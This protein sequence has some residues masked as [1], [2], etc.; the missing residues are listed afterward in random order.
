MKK[1]ILFFTL[2]GFSV[3]IILVI[4]TCKKEYSYE[5]GPL[6]T[7]T[8]V[9]DPDE[10]TNVII[11]GNYATSIPLDST[12]YV[13]VTAHVTTAGNYT[14]STNTV[15]GITFSAAGN[16]SDTGFYD[17]ILKAS[18]TPGPEG[19]YQL[20]IVGNS[21]CFFSIEVDAK[22]M[23]DYVLSGNLGD[24]ESPNIQG[25]YIASV[26]LG[27]SNTVAVNVEVFVPGD[28][29]ISTDTAAGISF[30]ASGTFT[31]TGKQQVT[32]QGSG[33]PDAPGLIYFNVKGGSSQ[34]AFKLSIRNASPVATYVLQ[35]G[36]GNPNPCTPQTVNGSY[37]ALQP[38]S[39]GNTVEISAYVTV[40][41]NFTVSTDST[42][43]MIFKYSGEFTVVGEQTVTLEGSGTPTIPGTYSFIPQIIGPAPLG[44][45]SCGFSIPV[46]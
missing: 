4:S 26:L 21:T 13:Q 32:L 39:S 24:C 8:L 2:L 9:G 28:Y 20:L 17:V 6:A 38:L 23:A 42:N 22:P 12:D 33:T 40:P 5:G 1:F 34:C 7:Y 10:C 44:G 16:F 18:G 46:K 25:N 36:F 35:S 27:S 19:V 11:N 37:T 45:A 43:G 31:V 29:I 15:N 30:S 14:I 41:G 3:F